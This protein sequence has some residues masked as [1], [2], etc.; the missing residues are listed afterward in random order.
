[1]STKTLDDEIEVTLDMIEAGMPHALRIDTYGGMSDESLAQIIADIYRAM[2]Q[3][4]VGR[5]GA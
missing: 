1:M 2:R 5:C 3:V 4:E